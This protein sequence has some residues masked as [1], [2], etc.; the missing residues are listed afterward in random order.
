MEDFLFSAYKAGYYQL[1]I[2]YGYLVGTSQ[3]EPELPE[4][5]KRLLKSI[6]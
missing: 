3:T 2:Q 1:V 4:T 6:F 5:E